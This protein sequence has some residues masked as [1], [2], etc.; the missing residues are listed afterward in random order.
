MAYLP[1]K[2]CLNGGQARITEKKS[3]F[4]ANVFPIKTEEEATLFMEDIKKQYW[5]AKHHC[6]A[7]VTG[8]GGL[9]R[10]YSDDGEPQKTA[11]VPILEVLLS[12]GIRDVCVLVTRYFGGVLLG[13]G[14]LVR[15]YQSA[16]LAG[17]EKSEIVLKEKGVMLRLDTDYELLGKLRYMMEQEKVFIQNIEYTEKITISVVIPDEKKE[18]F[19]TG[20]SDISAGKIAPTFDDFEE[21]YFAKK[22]KEIILFS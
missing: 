16:A 2:I 19:L 5:D 15:A 20:L 10:R 13:T 11:G 12:Q 14:G 1:Y 8:E 18:S 4:I 21:V 22:E 3:R 9:I 7:L 17:L 6:Y